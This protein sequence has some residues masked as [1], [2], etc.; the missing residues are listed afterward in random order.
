M[1]LAGDIGGTKTN[2]GLF[3]AAGTTLVR[4]EVGSFR[5]ADY[6]S[7]E[8]IVREFLGSG[9]EAE[10]AC[11]GVAGPVLSDESRMTNLPWTVRGES[12]R[13]A[14]GSRRCFLVNDLFATACAVPRLSPGDFSVL[15]AGKAEPRGCMAVVA[16]GTGLGVSFLVPTGKGYLPFPSE[17]GH[18]GFSPRDAREISIRS[19]FEERYGRVSVE[20]MVS[21]PGLF[22]IYRYLREREGF[23]ESAQVEARLSGED[24][25][26]VISE[27]G[28]GGGSA[29]SREAL[30]IF[31]SLYG[32]AAGDYALEFLAT[33][34]VVLG[35]GIAP[36]ILPVLR[37]GPFLDSFRDKGRFR[38]LL[39]T[40]PVKVILDDKAPLLGAAHY[41]LESGGSPS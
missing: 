24:P 34:G 3:R 40:I 29:A 5:N 36:A 15:Q 13:A 31:A 39:S 28:M 9:R 38:D 27:E 1:I 17:G 8:S 11:F 30:R 20:R 19:W 18:A 21:G 26:A 32:G 35:G 23:P 4:E 6:P 25:P 2:L 41:A 7:L 12:L 14:S 33:G 37:K 16:A 10:L 22:G